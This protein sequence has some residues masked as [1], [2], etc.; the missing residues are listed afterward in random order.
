MSIKTKG[1]SPKTVAVLEM[2]AAGYTYEQV[3]T[4]YPDLNYHDIFGAAREALQAAGQADSNYA[5]RLAKIKQANPRAYEKWGDEEG[6]TLTALFRSGQRT[7]EIA[8]KL[9]RQPSAIRSRIAKLGLEE[10]VV[11]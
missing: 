4:A 6:A 9:Q 1:L 10:E 2:I 5:E 7:K 8:A 11:K 3:L